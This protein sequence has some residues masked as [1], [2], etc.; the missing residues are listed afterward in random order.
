VKRFFE[1]L[2]HLTQA[3]TSGGDTAITAP[4]TERASDVQPGGLFVARI[5]ASFDGHTLIPQAV[6]NGAAAIVGEKAPGAIACPVPYASV[7]DARAVLAPLAAAYHDFPSRKLIVTGVTGTDGKTTT[8]TLLHHILQAAGFRAGLISTVSA[9]LGEGEQ[10]TG[11]HVTTPTAPEVQGYLAQMV[12]AGLTHAVLETTSHGLAQGRV[13]GVDFDV[14]VLT[15]VSHEHL[16][17]H[18]TWEAYRDA[19]ALLFH[20]TSRAAPKTGQPKVTVINADD[21][22]AAFFYAI[23]ADRRLRYSTV[24]AD[25]DFY[26][27]DITHA[28]EG[29]RFTLNGTV[30]RSP[31]VGLYNVSNALAA[32][33]AAAGLAV[34]GDAIRRGIASAPPI[35]GRMERLDEGQDFLAVVDFAHTPNSLR[36]VLITARALIDPGR[37]VIGV[38]G[39]A[40]LRDRA[41]RRMMAEVAAELADLVILTAEDPRTESLDDILEEMAAGCRCR[42]R[43]EGTDFFRVPDRGRALLRAVELA[44]AGDVVLACGKGHEQSMCFGTVEVPWDDRQALRSAL[45]GVPLLTLPTAPGATDS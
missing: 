26:A 32:M 19:K 24:Q 43:I 5:G 4:V 23:Q 20:K 38:V 31:L 37:R 22:A 36:Q 21:P 30:I 44:A 10:A 7:P 34:P 33:A 16:D 42:G 1:L 28:P 39:S 25:V 29:T 45:R 3:S 18:G 17:Y 8:V 35:P 41:K 13:D 14:A 15:N 2:E 6:A 40:G 9:L 27:A 12:E 11:L